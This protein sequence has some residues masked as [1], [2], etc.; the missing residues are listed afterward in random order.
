MEGIGI[1]KDFEF[2]INLIIG[3]FQCKTKQTINLIQYGVAIYVP[4]T[5]NTTNTLNKSISHQFICTHNFSF[6][7][8]KLFHILTNTVSYA[9]SFHISHYYVPL[10]ISIA[11][12]LMNIYN[13]Y[14][15]V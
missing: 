13:I 1:W 5:Y 15:M 9:Y 6:F 8:I 4:P 10:Q 2:W 14:T 7:C 3:L 12:Y 11:W